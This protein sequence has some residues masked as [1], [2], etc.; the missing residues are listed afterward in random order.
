[1][2]ERVREREGDRGGGGRETWTA[3]GEGGK[4]RQRGQAMGEKDERSTCQS[5]DE[6]ADIFLHLSDVYV[7]L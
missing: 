5:A 2:R 4:D 3:G 1:V 7:Y 6:N